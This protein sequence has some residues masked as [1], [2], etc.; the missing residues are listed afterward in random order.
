MIGNEEE[1]L[2]VLL[3][4]ILQTELTIARHG[5]DIGTA[6]EGDQVIHIGRGG[7]AKEWVKGDLHEGARMPGACRIECLERVNALVDLC[8]SLLGKIARAD[9]FGNLAILCLYG[10]VARGVGKLNDLD[11]GVLQC[12]D[13]LRGGE[14]GGKDEG[15]TLRYE[16]LEIG[17]YGGADDGDA[18][19][20]GSATVRGA[21]D[22]ERVASE[23]VE[24]VAH[25]GN[26]R[27]DAWRLR[28]VFLLAR[29][30][31]TDQEREQK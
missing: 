15:R 18:V 3:D 24:L 4:D 28:L 12:G 27:D 8:E 6:A 9:D 30:V 10:V 14:V 29:L 7:G 1:H 17:L 13:G 23:V 25:G 20:N 21:A 26:E 11:A 16:E 19:G 31:A 2:G 5:D 22:E